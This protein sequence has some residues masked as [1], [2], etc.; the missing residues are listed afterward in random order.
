MGERT[1][2][3]L[4]DRQAFRDEIKRLEIEHDWALDASKTGLHTAIVVVGLEDDERLR[5]KLEEVQRDGTDAECMS[6]GG[7]R[8]ISDSSRCQ[9]CLLEQI[10]H[11]IRVLGDHEGETK[12]LFEAW[13]DG[14]YQLSEND[15]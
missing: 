13:L 15:E 6:C 8:H 7:S 11:C 10:D 9:N 3:L 2:V 12:S 5:R 14:D 4:D 1:T